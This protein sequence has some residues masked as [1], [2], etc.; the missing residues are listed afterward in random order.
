MPVYIEPP[1]TMTEY[2]DVQR[3]TRLANMPPE[4]FQPIFEQ[5][6]RDRSAA[7]IKALYTR[8]KTWALLHAEA[9]NGDGVAIT[10][11]HPIHKNFGRMTAHGIVTVPRDIRGYMCQSDDG[12]A[13]MTDLDMANCHPVILEWLCKRHGLAC[14]KLTYF[15]EHRGECMAAIQD[16]TQRS[17][18]DVKRMFLCAVNSQSELE[19]RDPFL[20]EFDAECKQ[21]QQAFLVLDEYRFVLEHAER[22][23]NLK[24]DEIKA[25]RRRERRTVNGLTANVAGA[26]INLVLCTWE[27]RLL[28]TACAALQK[29]G[30]EVC[31]NCFDGVLIRGDHY[32]ADG[33]RDDRIC[34]ALERA[35][36]DEHGITMSW[37]MKPHSTTLQWDESEDS[38]LKYPYKV[39]RQKWLD[40]VF[41]VGSMY[42]VRLQNGTEVTESASQLEQRLRGETVRCFIPEKKK[43]FA[44]ALLTDLDLRT[45]EACDMYPRADQCPSFIYNTWRPMTCEA[46]DVAAGNPRSDG[47]R[48]VR[49]LIAV[50][51]D[52]KPAVVKYI[53]LFIAHML[54]YPA[55]KPGTY[56]VLMSPE[57]AGKGTLVEILSALMGSHLVKELNNVQRSLL[58]NFNGALLDAFLIV[59]DEAQ[60]KHLF[61]G[62]EE[63][64]H[65]ITAAEHSVN[66]KGVPERTVKSYARFIVT[67]QPRAVPTKRGDRRAVISLSSDVLVGDTS[68]F[69]AIRSLLEDP[70]FLLDLNA[71]FRSLD[72]PRV[73]APEDTPV[74]EVQSE[75]QQGN[76]DIF[77]LWVAD[78]VERWCSVSPNSVRDWRGS[79]SLLDTTP[80]MDLKAMYADF[81]DFAPPKVVESIRYQSFVSRF[82]LCR[83]SKAF[84]TK[85]NG[86]YPRHKYD[87]VQLQCRQWDMRKIARDLGVPLAER[88][89]EVIVESFVSRLKMRAQKA[90]SVK[91]ASDKEKRARMWST[92]ASSEPAP[93]PAPTTAPVLELDPT[94]TPASKRPLDGCVASRKKQRYDAFTD[95][96]S[97]V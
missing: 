4:R 93:A 9:A 53:E 47:V 49:R 44:D 3:A 64:K 11:S 51:A 37:T 39:Y 54:L 7:S 58:G 80:H 42:V 26:F 50:L 5:S 18:D 45:Y 1:R 83:W 48:M 15:V 60:G 69:S 32:P 30:Y 31:A 19:S 94:S 16:R 2:C 96:Y 95:T 74:T 88:R 73:F 28:G 21:L 41:R 24:L 40:R 12:S 62:S 8:I 10:Y 90:L 29:D 82:S 56:L 13:L 78:V 97:D 59:L 57:G 77:E 92:S 25:Q 91:R 76:A 79:R 68:F 20:L 38:T 63:L 70:Q 35:L 43:N 6:S 55:T 17:R 87:G 67:I 66:Q 89:V 84:N 46:F 61:D 85:V 86:G 14:P 23:A 81:C 65:L 34:P 71:Y 72:P 52:F 22:A 75:M 33:T 27:N 36:L